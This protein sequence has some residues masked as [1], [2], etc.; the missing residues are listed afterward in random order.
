MV[1]DSGRV[2]GA[3]AVLAAMAAAE[4]ENWRRLCWVGRIRLG[5]DIGE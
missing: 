4:V 1:Y 2:V 3:A 5:R